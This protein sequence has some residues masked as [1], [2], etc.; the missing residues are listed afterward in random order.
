MVWSAFA[1]A[2][3]SHIG[4]ALPYTAASLA[5]ASCVVDDDGIFFFWTI[6]LP[7][8]VPDYDGSGSCGAS[9]WRGL[10][11]VCASGI[12]YWSCVFESDG[13]TALITFNSDIFCNSEQIDTAVSI[14]TSA[15]VAIDCPSG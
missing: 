11:D 14:A 5:T 3:L 12:T 7:N 15:N 4:T 10:Q 9:V 13:T 6:T 2:L 8:D 1:G